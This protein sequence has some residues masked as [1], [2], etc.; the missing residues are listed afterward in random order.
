M[1]IKNAKLDEVGA[2]IDSEKQVF[3]VNVD[4]STSVM[5]KVQAIAGESF[6]RL[7]Y[8]VSERCVSIS[9]LNEMLKRTEEHLSKILET[10]SAFSMSVSEETSS[11]NVSIE[12]KDIKAFLSALSE[13]PDARIVL[14]IS[15][16]DG[17]MGFSARCG[18]SAP[19]Y[20][21]ALYKNSTDSTCSAACTTGFKVKRLSDGVVGM[22]SAG[23]CR[24]FQPSWSGNLYSSYA[25]FGQF[26]DWQFG[27]NDDWS[28]ITSSSFS[29]I[30]YTDPCSPCTRTSA[31][32]AVAS[33]GNTICISGG[34]TGARCSMSITNLNVQNCNQGV[35]VYN[36]EGIR[37]DHSLSCQLG[38]S[39]GPWFSSSTSKVY[40]VQSFFDGTYKCYYNPVGRMTAYGY[41]VMTS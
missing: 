10:G 28:F 23:H 4:P 2:W 24:H 5:E 20:G 12:K 16:T 6:S 9:D 25:F 40:G 27:G 32:A 39:G 26:S 22:S 8:S 21:G 31:G 11:V 15:P 36:V 37:N 18:D 38:D 3:R 35:C 33:V 17:Q 13:V 30:Y 1:K 34:V 29:P 7:N 19:H 41:Q 14:E